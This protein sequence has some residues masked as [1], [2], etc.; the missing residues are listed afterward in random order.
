MPL[1]ARI[2]WVH[3]Q[4]ELG[5][6]CHITIG[7][8]GDEGK[9][10]VRIV[11]HAATEGQIDQAAK[12]GV[13]SA[14]S[15]V[16]NFVA[17]YSAMDRG[18]KHSNGMSEIAIWITVPATAPDR[19]GAVLP[20][21][22]ETNIRVLPT[23]VRPNDEAIDGHAVSGTLNPHAVGSVTC[24]DDTSGSRC[25]GV[26]S[27][28]N[29]FIE[30]MFDTLVPKINNS[31]SQLRQRRNKIE[32]VEGMMRMV[33]LEAQDSPE[34]GSI[35]ITLRKLQEEQVELENFALTRVD[36]L[37]EDLMDEVGLLPGSVARLTVQ[38]ALHELMAKELKC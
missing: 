11:L 16:R 19:S 24:A 21:D 14:L 31:R 7:G 4:V 28:P 3:Q 23:N 33:P 12:F 10:K 17:A 36:A 32:E 35:K 38:D 22:S 5:R 13:H 27:V 15:L 8:A 18:H 26:A 29:G 6:K 2:D 20:D 37:I 1:L 25:D 30:K 34:C 9:M